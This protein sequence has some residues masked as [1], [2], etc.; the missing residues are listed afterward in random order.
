M[1]YD[2]ARKKNFS[3]RLSLSLWHSMFIVCSFCVVRKIQSSRRTKMLF[4]S[5]KCWIF[6]CLA[7]GSITKF[8]LNILIFFLEWVCFFFVSFPII[9]TFYHGMWF[10]KVNKMIIF[11][12]NI[13]YF[14]WLVVFGTSQIFSSTGINPIISYIF[15]ISWLKRLKNY[16]PKQVECFS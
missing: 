2:R 12:I 4:I 15:I 7:L 1:F 3:H 13:L 11:F 16:T 6:K 10:G 8:A 14:L 5:R 9:H